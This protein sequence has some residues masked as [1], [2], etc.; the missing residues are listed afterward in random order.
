TAEASRSP[1][2]RVMATPALAVGDFMDN[3]PPGESSSLTWSVLALNAASRRIP[4][5][6]ATLRR[7]VTVHKSYKGGHISEKSYL[8]PSQW[9]VPGQGRTPRRYCVPPGPGRSRPSLSTPGKRRP[10]PG[11]AHTHEGNSWAAVEGRTRRKA[12]GRLT[13]ILTT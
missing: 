13:A 12:A 4:N 5:A 8:T 1:A 11:G 3:V 10:L 2:P 9:R 6:D 7:A